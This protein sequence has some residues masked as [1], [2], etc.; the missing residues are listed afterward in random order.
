MELEQK[1]AVQREILVG[2]WK[3]HILYHAASGPVVGQWMLTELRRH[4]YDVSPGTLYPMLHRL[5][6]LGWLRSE[7]EPEMGSKSRR[8]FYLTEKGSEI[9]ETVRE[10]LGE[11]RLEV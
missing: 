2:F 9:L 4:G 11:L 10:C 3:V 8:S 1:K 6:K 5:E 7:V